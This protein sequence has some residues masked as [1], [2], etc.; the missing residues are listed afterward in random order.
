MS[1]INEVLLA[2]IAMAQTDNLYANIKIGAMP[3]SNGI[4]MYVGAGAPENT[5]MDKGFEYEIRVTCNGK[6]SS[7]QTVSDAL[8]D[9]HQRLTQS[10]DYP[11]ANGWQITDINTNSTPSYIEV[12]NGN[13]QTLYGSVLG[14]KFYYKKG[15]EVT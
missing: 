12:D 6:H 5:F 11:S 9:I 2:V 4:S 10:K 14:V 13:R 7:A 3:E 15:T 8:N 1:V